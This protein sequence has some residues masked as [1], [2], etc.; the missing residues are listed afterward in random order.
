MIPSNKGKRSSYLQLKLLTFLTA[1]EILHC[2]YINRPL[3]ICDSS[4]L[5][6]NQTWT[7]DTGHTWL[8]MREVGSK[9]DRPADHRLRIRKYSRTFLEVWRFWKYL[10]LSASTT[11]MN[12]IT[13]M[14]SFSFLV[15]HNAA[16]RIYPRGQML[17]KLTT[18]KSLS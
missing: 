4:T 15:L 17:A 14:D 16:Q 1:L 13:V 8:R 11:M 7:V 3:G 2:K 10:L 6:L 5:M 9:I 12:L 18:I